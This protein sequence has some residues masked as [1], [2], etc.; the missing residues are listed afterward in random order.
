MN[1]R[2][3]SFFGVTMA[4]FFCVAALTENQEPPSQDTEQMTDPKKIDERIK[5]LKVMKRGYDS[6]AIWHNDQAERLQFDH[7]QLQLAKKHWKIADANRDVAKKIQSE[8]ELLERQKKALMQKT[9]L[10]I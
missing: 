10:E 1:K 5:E 3:F 2:I 4:F 6:K 9:T 8:I 7:G